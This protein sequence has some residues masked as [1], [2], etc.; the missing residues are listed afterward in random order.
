M[1]IIVVRIVGVNGLAR[2]LTFSPLFHL[3]G[4]AEAFEAY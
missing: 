3:E 1:R 2:G 4:M